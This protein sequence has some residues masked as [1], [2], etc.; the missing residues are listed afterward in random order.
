MS[1]YEVVEKFVSIN[2]EGTKAG[3]LAVFIRFKGCNLK[4]KYCDTK[5]ANEQDTLYQPM[6]EEE[7]LA[8]FLGC[9]KK[10]LAIRM[11]Q[12]G[13]LKKEYLDN[14]FDLVT[15]YPEVSEL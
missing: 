12:L 3:Q 8:D 9:S 11:K 6:T 13:L 10:A 4:C 15:V 5:W 7:I 1:K 2:G 14:P